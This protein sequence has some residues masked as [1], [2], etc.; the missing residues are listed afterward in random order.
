[1]VLLLR[2]WH[3][4]IL[5]LETVRNPISG[6][7]VSENAYLEEL[8]RHDDDHETI[9]QVLNL[10]VQALISILATY[11]SATFER[12]GDEHAMLGQESS[13]LHDVAAAST[14]ECCAND[15]DNLGEKIIMLLQGP[16][17]GAAGL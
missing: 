15:T 11:T 5:K 3:D 14:D 6:C 7:I 13:A 12:V 4:F 9:C 16:R 2:L 8:S 10:L 1:M 17:L